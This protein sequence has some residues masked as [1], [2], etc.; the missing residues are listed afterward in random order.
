MQNFSTQLFTN[1]LLFYFLYFITMIKYTPLFKSLVAIR[2][3]LNVFE[4]LLRS[5][6]LHLFDHNFGKNII[7][8]KH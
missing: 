1:H 7:F 6:R 8:V 2:F 4:S 5:P 3:F